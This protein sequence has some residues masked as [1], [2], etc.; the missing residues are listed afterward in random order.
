MATTF[1]TE[2]YSFNYSAFASIYKQGR[3]VRVLMSVTQI[4]QATAFTGFQSKVLNWNQTASCPIIG[5]FGL[6]GGR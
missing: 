3:H 2:I 5:S 6:R 1:R 4:Y